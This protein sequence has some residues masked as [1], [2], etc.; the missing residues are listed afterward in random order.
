MTN[1]QQEMSFWQHLTELRKR[2]LYALIGIAVGIVI[3][4][5]F[6]EQ[7]LDLVAKP[8]GGFDSLLSIE[9]TENIGVFMRVTLL[10]G[11]ILSLPFT[12]I[13]LYLFVQPALNPPE[14]RWVLLAVPLA[15]ILFLVGAGFSY[16]VMLPNAIP[17]LVQF[18]GPEVLPKWK[19]YVDFVTSLIFWSGISFEM[20]LLAFVL[21][22]IGIISAAQLLKGWRIAIIVIAF[23]AALITPTGDPINMIILMVPLILLF[24]LSILLAALAKKDKQGEQS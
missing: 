6:A 4:L 9:V 20:P 2:L 13:Q 15:V 12:F 19:D 11:F 22:R 18:Y 16:L 17:V 5:V 23:A 14:R 8:I 21:A 3:A 1:D 10:G 7:I 24:A